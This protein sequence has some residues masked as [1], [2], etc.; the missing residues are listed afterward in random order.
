MCFETPVCVAID[1]PGGAG[2][3]TI[4]RRLAKALGFLYLDTGALYRAVA[5]A[6]LSRGIDP[7][8]TASIEALLPQLSVKPEIHNGEQTVILNGE[9]IGLRIRTPAVSAAASK[10]SAIPQVRR[11]LLDLQ[12]DTAK[13]HSV[14]MDGRDIGTVVM[15]NAKVKI[16]L[17]A[18][19]RDR[20]QRRYEE[21]RQKGESVSYEEVLRDMKERDYRDEH[22]D[23]A[24][25]KSAEDA[26]LVDTT[27]NTLEES[28]ALM[29]GIV[30]GKLNED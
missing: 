18:D 15:P 26:I 20:A 1:G 21:L 4:A 28:V 9:D 25:L 6:A 24:P 7:A 10:I 22:R 5:Y 13:T 8:D 30:E 19:V 23:T 14:I 12:R 11:F 17:S 3:S 29:R 27:G 2:K 16:F